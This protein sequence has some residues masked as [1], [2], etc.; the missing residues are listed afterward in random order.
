MPHVHG[1]PLAEWGERLLARIIDCLAVAVPVYLVIVLLFS[2]IQLVTVGTG[3]LQPWTLFDLLA[4]LSVVA[5][6]VV[7]EF[8]MLTRANGR[9]LGKMALGLR[10]VPQEHPPQ[11]D[12]NLP[13]NTALARGAVWWGPGLIDFILPI[14]M[15]GLLLAIAFVLVNGLW[16]LWDQPWRHSLNDKFTGTVVVKDR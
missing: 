10:V 7:Y 8:L 11:Q 9:T 13:P 6:L 4:G 16:P 12:G 14:P 5:G 3:T 15:I 1:K 2:V